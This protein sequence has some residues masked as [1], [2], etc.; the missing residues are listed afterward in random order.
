M[1]IMEQK[2]DT[3]KATRNYLVDMIAFLPFL[4]L[5]VTG[6]IMLMYHAGKPYSE[7]TMGLTGNVWLITHKILTVIALPLIMVHLFFHYEWL[8]K[9]F[10]FTLKNKHK[11]LNITLFVLFIL[12]VLTSL[13]SWLVFNDSNIGKAMK[14]IH[15]KFG[16]LL[17][18]FFVIHISN[19]F[20]W[21]VNMT[22]IILKKK[23]NQ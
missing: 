12:C 14:G 8:K 23:K 11:G 21:I 3:T 4:L 7:E 22:K 20:K 19:Y 18:I 10:T 13:L 15:N 16:I 5:L 9:L 1:I 17:I 6:I 2:I